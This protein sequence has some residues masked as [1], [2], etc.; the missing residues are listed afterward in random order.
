[1]YDPALRIGGMNHFM[2]PSGES[3][4]RP[5]RYGVHAMELLINEVMK[6]GGERSRLRAKVFGGASVIR[7][8][9][10]GLDVGRKN[11]DFIRSFLAAER[12]PIEAERL[13][14]INPLEVRFQTDS[15]VARVRALEAERDEVFKTEQ[16]VSLAPGVAPIAA[17]ADDVDSVLF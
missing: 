11:A 6:L 5:A 13:G 15:S 1:V 17:T 14:G 2:L 4:D 7:A 12:I 3:N 10:S 9:K 16:Q 8:L